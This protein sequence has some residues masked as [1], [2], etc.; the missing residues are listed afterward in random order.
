M[1]RRILA[2][3]ISVWLLSGAAIA[4]AGSLN[5]NEQAVINVAKGQFE[6]DGKMYMAESSY[7][8]QLVSYLSSDEIDLT[9]D[10]MEEAIAQMYANVEEGVTQGYLLPVEDQGDDEKI[11]DD[12][13]DIMTSLDADNDVIVSRSTS[14]EKIFEQEVSTPSSDVT[15]QDAGSAS[16]TAV[17]D[18]VIKNTGFNL[19]TTFFIAVG[20]AML[21]LICMIETIKSDFFAHN[22][23]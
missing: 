11:S 20:A 18:T 12:Q 9:E 7:V 23:E 22:D 21:M 2:V 10:Q 5:A 19:N 6:V 3:G 13:T 1:K 4:Y 15:N 16:T 17:V 8:N 14:G